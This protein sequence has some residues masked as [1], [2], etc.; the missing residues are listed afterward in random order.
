M[1]LHVLVL[2]VLEQYKIENLFEVGRITEVSLWCDINEE[3]SLQI[4]FSGF[5]YCVLAV[6]S[7]KLVLCHRSKM[8]YFS[9]TLNRH[10]FSPVFKCL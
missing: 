3:F 5:C 9:F 7:V 4:I 8:N 10:L 6:L 2:F 1:V